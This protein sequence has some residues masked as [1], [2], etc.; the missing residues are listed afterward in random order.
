[1]LGEGGGEMF[2]LGVNGVFVYSVCRGGHGVVSVGGL[3]RSGWE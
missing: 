2:W 1:M 3:K